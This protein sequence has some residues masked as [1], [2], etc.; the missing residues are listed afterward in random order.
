MSQKKIRAALETA[1][2]ALGE[3]VP[4]FDILTCTAGSPAR[5]TSDGP[6]LLKTGVNVSIAGHVGGVADGKYTFVEINATTFSLRTRVAEAAIASVAGGVGGVCTAKLT[7]WDNL[8]FAPVPGVPYQKVN[9]M[10]AHPDNPTMGSSHYR[11]VG[12][13]QVALYYKIHEGTSDISTRAELI[14]SA[15]PRGASFEKDGVVVHVDKTPEIMRGMP[16]DESY[17]V[18]VRIPFY[19]DIFE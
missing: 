10:F 19:A 18:P 11:E 17:V 8:S 4:A 16:V 3:T 1:L 2:A 7:A 15:F 12:F 6:H 13:M 5:F 9:V 14:R